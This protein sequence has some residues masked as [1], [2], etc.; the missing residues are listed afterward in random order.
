MCVINSGG[1]K[2]IP[3][4]R[5]VWGGILTVFGAD[6][7][8]LWHVSLGLAFVESKRNNLSR[9]IGR[10]CLQIAIANLF[11]F[12][13]I[14]VVGFFVVCLYLLY[15]LVVDALSLIFLV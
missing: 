11:V 1:G 12:L 9:P 2:R 15:E 4:F 8:S 10:L 7:S 13:F 5:G 14:A 6:R 3:A